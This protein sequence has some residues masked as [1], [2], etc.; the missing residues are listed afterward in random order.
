MGLKNTFERPIKRYSFEQVSQKGI[1]RSK[2]TKNDD[3]VL[4]TSPGV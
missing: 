2:G 4:S 1:K 3:Q